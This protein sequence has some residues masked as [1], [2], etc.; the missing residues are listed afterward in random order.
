MTTIVWASSTTIGVEGREP[1]GRACASAAPA[2]S[3]T[4]RDRADK[5]NL[6]LLIAFSS[7]GDLNG[8]NTGEVPPSYPLRLT[9]L[10]AASYLTVM[11][12]VS[13]EEAKTRLSELAGLAEKGERVVITR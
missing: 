9:K 2:A 7:H 13:I 12:T 6:N 11:S 4:P 10:A 3:M 1:M 5:P 8:P